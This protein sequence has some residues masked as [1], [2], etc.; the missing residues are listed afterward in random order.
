MIE[1]VKYQN[2]NPVNAD[3][4]IA[5]LNQEKA[6]LELEA[7]RLALEQNKINFESEMLGYGSRLDSS[8]K[9]QI[10]R[11]QEI[12]SGLASAQIKYKQALQAYRNTELKA[13]FSG[14][15]ANL[16]ITPGNRVNP[17]QQVGLLYAPDKMQIRVRVLETEMQQLR[18]GATAEVLPLAYPN[19]P[20][21]A[22][23]SQINP[24][25]SEDGLIELTFD[26]QKPSGLLSGMNATVRRS[27]AADTSLLVPREAVVIRSGKEVVFLYHPEEQLAKWKYVTTGRENAEEVQILEGLEEGDTAIVTNNLQLAHDA[28]VTVVESGRK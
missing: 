28:P 7:A 11:T 22:S 14:I 24:L 26:I 17:G 13:P 2:G 1:Q 21:S 10:I 27:I 6:E 15:L 4:L 20:Y 8:N 23:L 19:Q 18:K 3:S 12:N 16:N 5:A 9:D 25:V